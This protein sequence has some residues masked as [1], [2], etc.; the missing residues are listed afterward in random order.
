MGRESTSSRAAL[1]AREGHMGNSP[2]AI[3]P[4][5]LVE[6]YEV[7]SANEEAIEAGQ[8][9]KRQMLDDIRTRYGRR[10]AEAL[11]VA[12]RLMRLDPVK[13]AE[14]ILFAEDAASL[15]DTL[16]TETDERTEPDRSSADVQ[17]AA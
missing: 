10:A 8:R 13:R 3:P 16:L 4:D 2:Q 9:K 11:R 1:H 7:W 12:M 15:V 17:G 6:F 5:E 14:A